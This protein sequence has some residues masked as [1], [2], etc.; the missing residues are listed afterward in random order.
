[1]YMLFHGLLQLCT[2]LKISTSLIVSGLG[3]LGGAKVCRR[4]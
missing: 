4:N 3:P 2:Q 1:M